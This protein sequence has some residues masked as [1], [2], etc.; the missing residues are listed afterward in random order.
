MVNRVQTAKAIQAS[1]LEKLGTAGVDADVHL[2]IG[3]MRPIDRD[4]QQ[5]EISKLIGPNRNREKEPLAKP[6]FIV[7]T[8]TLEVGADYDFDALITECASIDA[9]RQRFGRLNRK[10]RPIEI[11]ASILITDGA[12]KD[13]DPIYGDALRR[14]W[15]WLTQ[16]GR[17]TIDLGIVAFESLWDKVAHED[18]QSMLAPAPDAAVLLPAHLDALCQTSPQPSPSP[19]ISYFIHGPQRDNREVQVC[20]RAD[21]GEEPAKWPDIVALLAPTSARAYVTRV[22]D[23]PASRS[24]TVDARRGYCSGRCRR[25]RLGRS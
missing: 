24:A 18:R 23:G 6:V 13:T 11:A 4:Q 25:S 7:A 10:G 22:H 1:I 21:L 19:D 15:A 5:A 9:L 17:T 8:Q 14:T 3:R 20:W 16:G 12:L 2:V